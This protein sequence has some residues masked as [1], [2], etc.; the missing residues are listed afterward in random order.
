MDPAAGTTKFNG[1]TVLIP[2]LVDVG[3]LTVVDCRIVPAL[4]LNAIVAVTLPDGV[5][6]TG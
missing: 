4:F 5:V 2:G 3:T 1:T 6:A